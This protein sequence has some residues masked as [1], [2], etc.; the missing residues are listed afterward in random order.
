MALIKCPECN[1]EVSEKAEICPH[2]GLSIKEYQESVKRINNT[3]REKD[4]LKSELNKKLKEIDKLPQPQKPKFSDVLFSERRWLIIVFLIPAI[5]NLVAFFAML[6]PFGKFEWVYAIAFLIFSILFFYFFSRIKE[7]YQD[8]L[9]VYED[10][11][12][13]KLEQKKEVIELYEYKIKYIEKHGYDEKTNVQAIPNIGLKCPVCGSTNV[14]RLSNLNR[15]ISV[16]LWGV[17]SSKIGKQ[18]E[19][20]MCKHKW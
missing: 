15:G 6:I 12:G 7:A 1:R 5:V 20:R 16:E 4:R 19:C 2:C 13:Y 9:S 10:F 3:K 11:E 18:Y 8:R 17:A 14:K